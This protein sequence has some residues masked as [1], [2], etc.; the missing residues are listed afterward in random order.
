MTG[1]EQ[2]RVLCLVQQVAG[3]PEV[4]GIVVGLEPE[5]LALRVVAGRDPRR[6][7]RVPRTH[8]DTQGAPVQPAEL[9][10][11]RLDHAGVADDD[12]SAAWLRADDPA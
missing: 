12:S 2:F 7:R 11:G 4:T 3:D 9:D 1:S 5:D 10:E 8:G 6:D